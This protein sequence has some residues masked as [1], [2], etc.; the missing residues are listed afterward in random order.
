MIESV[1][2]TLPPVDVTDNE[3]PVS[4]TTLLP[5]SISK[6]EPAGTGALVNNSTV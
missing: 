3:S 1:T 6:E 4:N 2:S 5:E